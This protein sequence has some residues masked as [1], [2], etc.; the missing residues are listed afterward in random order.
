[1]TNSAPGPARTSSPIVIRPGDRIAAGLLRG[2]DLERRCTLE[3]R[4]C[5]RAP[6]EPA[7]QTPLSAPPGFL[8][9]LPALIF[10][11]A[12]MVYPVAQPVL[13]ELS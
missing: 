9:V 6:L 7:S 10:L 8:F 13:S 12:F 11:A 3:E 1:M 2:L 4:Q 5:T